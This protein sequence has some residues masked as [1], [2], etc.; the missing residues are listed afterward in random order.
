MRVLLSV[1]MLLGAA[2]PALAQVAPP[3]E[4]FSR[5]YE[6]AMAISPTARQLEAEQREWLKYRELDEYGYGADGDDERM[7]ALRR[8][9]ERDQTISRIRF[10]DGQRL[11]ECIGQALK[12]C[13]SPAGGWLTAP[14]GQRLYWQLQEGFT[15]EN[16]ITGGV[17]LMGD[18]GAARMGPVRPVAWAFEGYRYEAPT[19]LTFEG[20]LYVAVAGKMQGTGNGNADVI[21]RWTPGEVPE[22]IQVDNW[23]WRESLKERLP[24]G[25]EV[26][27]GVDFNYGDSEIWTWTPLWREGDGNCCASGGGAGL[28]F[29]IEDD[30][31]VLNSVSAHDTIVEVTMANP[32]D[33]LDFVGRWSM[34]QHWGGEEGYDAER[35]AQ[36]ENAVRE[37]RCDALLADAAH[38]ETKYSEDPATLA[39]IRRVR[40]E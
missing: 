38:L 24:A 16:G 32:I 13:S 11:D 22:L 23:S 1:L 34:C 6:A 3:S 21:F 18:A 17:V 28:S 5:A 8:Q 2:T 27:K 20:K 14:D 39:L 9:A 40:A 7:L 15:D 37:L 30:V 36:I 25:L 4:E 33:V 19:L 26:W 12:D 10:L 29:R 35:R 31:L